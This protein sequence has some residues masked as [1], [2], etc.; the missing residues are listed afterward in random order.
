MFARSLDLVEACPL[1]WLHVFPY[2]PRRGTPAARMPQV[3]PPVRKE[4]ARR[5]RAAGEAAAGRF[6]ESRVGLTEHVAVERKA[7]GARSNSRPPSRRACPARLSPARAGAPGREGTVGRGG[8]GGVSWLQRLK[9]GLSRSSERLADGIAG[10]FN[11]RRLDDDALEELE[12]LLIM[13]DLGPATASRLASGL[14]QTRFGNEVSGEEVRGV[15]AEE[16]A[17]LLEPVARPLMPDPAR[18]PH[19]I[20]VVGVNGTGKTTTIGKLAHAFRTEGRSVLLAAGDTFRAAAVEQLQLWGSASVPPSW[21]GRP[22]RTPPAS[23]STPT[24]RQPG[25]ASTYY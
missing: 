18:K 8:A 11:R 1:T 19:V 6:L 12:D 14:A 15:L 10:I 13:A 7:P 22:G 17:G 20:L 23:S 5:L 21:R 3:A 2:S 4:R 16:I 9:Q 25:T 24:R